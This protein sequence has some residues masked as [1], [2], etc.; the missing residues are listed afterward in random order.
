MTVGRFVFKTSARSWS[1][2]GSMIST[3]SPAV[4]TLTTELGQYHAPDISGLQLLI[5]TPNMSC[6]TL[7]LYGI[8]AASMH[9]NVLYYDLADSC[10]KELP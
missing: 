9:V 8:S 1:T 10:H 2:G 4:S 6:L 3:W 7:V 5:R